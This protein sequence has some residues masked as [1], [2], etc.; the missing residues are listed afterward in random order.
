MTYDSYH[1]ACKEPPEA[2]DID[3]GG[4]GQ[5]PIRRHVPATPSESWKTFLEEERTELQRRPA[6]RKVSDSPG[7][8]EEVPASE[9]P[10]AECLSPAAR[11]RVLATVAASIVHDF[12][13]VLAA[14]IGHVSLARE[15]IALDPRAAAED[16][17]AAFD[18]CRRARDLMDNLVA[19]LKKTRPPPCPVNLGSL[20]RRAVREV[21]DRVGTRLT[22]AV[23]GDGKH[24]VVMGDPE[25]LHEMVIHLCA[26]AVEAVGPRGG[27]VRV[28]VQLREAPCCNESWRGPGRWVV[29]EVSDDGP[30]IPPE[31]LRKVFDPFYTCRPAPKGTGLGLTIVKRT[32][33]AHGGTIDVTSEVGKGTTFTVCLPAASGASSPSREDR[34][35]ARVVT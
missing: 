21:Q 19:Y 5:S 11:R 30:G 34:R 4:G 7:S 23:R 12:N 10:F 20:T 31:H 8:W 25:E 9:P 16:L 2:T 18:V 35:L 33:Y 1:H 13:N 14:V 26:N 28:A 17:E 29:L 32:V 3:P 15:T 27:R 22:V 24:H 6:R